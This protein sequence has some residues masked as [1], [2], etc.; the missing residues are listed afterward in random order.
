MSQA[1][2]LRSARHA[3]VPAL[4]A[5]MRP[6]QWTKNLFLLAGVV[7]AGKLGDGT[8]VA[9]ALVAFVA[10]CLLS[11]AGYLVNDVRD[12]EHDRAHPTKRFRAVASGALAPR[13]AL[14]VAAALAL[15]GAALAAALGPLEL[16]FA[17]GFAGLQLA[18]SFRLKRVVVVDALTIA[19]LFVVRAA[20]GAEA[21]RVRISPWLLVC[22]ALLALFL[23][24]AKRRAELLATNGDTSSRAVLGRYSFRRLGPA[25]AVTAGGSFLA[26]TVYAF[27]GSD[28]AETALTVPL[29][30]FGL[31]RYLFLMLRRELGEEPDRMLLTDVPL[32]VTVALWAL[33]ATAI[34]NAA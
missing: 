7:F 29:V 34:L 18:Y 33:V 17:A 12:A 26:Y 21:T 27:T 30:A 25:V 22:T 5:A 19:A 11:S 9:R 28:S 4:V 20:A 31:A 15:A 1:A 10:Y 32:L 23:A 8:H 24:F 14:V 3:H 16:A 6:H 13:T 2:G